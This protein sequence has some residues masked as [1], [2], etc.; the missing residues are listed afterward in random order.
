VIHWF[1]LTMIALA[2]S[3]VPAVVVAELKGRRGM[4]IAGLSG[5]FPLLWVGAFQIGAP[6]SWWA[7]HFYGAEKLER[8][9]ERQSRRNAQWAPDHPDG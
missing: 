1:N 4:I 6:D 7:S 3:L 2:V 9:R 5:L 8:A